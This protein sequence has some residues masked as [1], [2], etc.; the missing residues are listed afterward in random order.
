MRRQD[1]V[2]ALLASDV[3]ID[4]DGTKKESAGSY[5]S[6]VKIPANFI[7]AGEFVLDVMLWSSKPQRRLDIE[8]DVLGF[9]IWDPMDE[10][11]LARGNFNTPVYSVFY[12]ALQWSFDRVLEEPCRR[13]M[14]Q[15]I[16]E[17]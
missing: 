12:P 2:N 3:P 11:C 5:M 8:Q 7:N 14:A 16:T 15:E 6:R 1:G 17:P 9:S 10:R 13:T 4:T